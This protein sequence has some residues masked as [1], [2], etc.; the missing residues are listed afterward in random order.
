M[1]AILRALA[2]GHTASAVLKMLAK[3]NPSLASKVNT[4]LSIGYTAEK[5]LSLLSKQTSES[6]SGVELSN[7]ERIARNSQRAGDVA[8]KALMTSAAIGAGGLLAASMQGVQN[9]LPSSVPNIGPKPMSNAPVPAPA[10]PNSPSIG[11]PQALSPGLQ[12]QKPPL[13]P[14]LKLPSQSLPPPPPSPS[15][16][17]GQGQAPL[18]KIPTQSQQPPSIDSPAIIREMGLEP[19]INNLLKA[20]NPPEL[21]GQV[22]SQQLR[23]G[24]KKWL[25][26][27]IKAGKAAPLP[28]LVKDFVGKTSQ[29]ASQSPT[30]PQSVSE[31]GNQGIFAPKAQEARQAPVKGEEI[32]TND[33]RVGLL[34]SER[35]GKALL[36]DDEGK[37]HQVSKKDYEPVPDD[38]KKI[39]VDLSKVPESSKSAALAEFM[40]SPDKKNVFVKYW[41][42]HKPVMYWYFK[43]DS[44]EF[45][46]DVLERIQEGLDAP[47]SSGV[48]FGGSW[49]QE[50]ADSRGSANHKEIKSQ[51]Q[52]LEDV[53]SG[54]MI[55]GKRIEN[56][57][58]KPLWFVRVPITFRHGMY[59]AVIDEL[60]KAEKLFDEEQKRKSKI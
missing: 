23:P 35:N 34:E 57:P 41:E 53:Q 26:D 51:A 60:K 17:Q 13:A 31:V 33:G 36:K 58:N 1:S 42:G 20:G 29:N 19:K 50:D 46:D 2:Q 30:V 5:I 45:S 25:D 32:I 8:K 27:Q 49:N 9:Q 7:S 38:W 37:L 21:V 59:E 47:I 55:K 28:D 12:A 11:R 39:T 3:S 40:P 24:E 52:S 15:G 22:L 44:G 18:G 56:D 14:P 6:R 4:A 10:I 48:K 43:K 54:R 16:M